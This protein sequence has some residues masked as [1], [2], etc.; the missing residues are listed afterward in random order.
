MIGGLSPQEPAL[1]QTES[2]ARANDSKGKKVSA[3]WKIRRRFATGFGWMRRSNAKRTL[4]VTATAA[5]PVPPHQE[6]AEVVIA[7]LGSDT[8]RGLSE[9][10]AHARLE[11][12]GPNELTAEKPV[13]RWRKFL[14]QFGD[15]L[16]ILLL[17]AAAISFA[18][19]IIGTRISAALRGDRHP[20]GRAAQ[21]DHGFH[22]G[23][24]RGIRSGRIAQD[25]CRRS[26]RDARVADGG[27]FRL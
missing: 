16:V 10:E 11:R 6:S 24:T 3:V 23:V 12:D 7:A 2:D 25:V 14:A 26:N 21:R 1:S 17:I 19:W 22:P 18:L 15:V 20:R 8:K 4:N 27:V 9:A 13:P 5:N